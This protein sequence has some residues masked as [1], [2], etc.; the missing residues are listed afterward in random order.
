MDFV[1]TGSNICLIS[2]KGTS[3]SLRVIV[4]PASAFI[5]AIAKTFPE[6]ISSNCS[7]FIP[8]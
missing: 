1:I 8:L 7:G 5:P 3:A 4:S 2:S 6:G